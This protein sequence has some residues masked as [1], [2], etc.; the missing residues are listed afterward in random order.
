MSRI[1]GWCAHIIEEKFAE[2]QPKPAIYRPLAHYIGPGS[3][4]KSLP[5]VAI[6]KRRKA[7]EA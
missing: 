1:S 6:E 3:T 5:Y 7:K 4:M 2:A